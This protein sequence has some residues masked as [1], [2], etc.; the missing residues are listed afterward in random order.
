MK[1]FFFICV[2]LIAFA[3]TNASG[4]GYQPTEQLQTHYQAHS[5][6]AQLPVLSVVEFVFDAVALNAVEMKA[7]V[8]CKAQQIF[9]P[10]AY[11]NPDYGLNRYSLS[12]ARIDYGTISKPTDFKYNLK[13][14]NH[15]LPTQFVQLE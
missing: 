13:Y 14:S 10:I 1:R 9:K 5:P 8:D 15:K 3:A 12:V 11:H 2:A 7:V 4:T 6:T